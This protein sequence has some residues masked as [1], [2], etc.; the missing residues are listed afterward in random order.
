MRLKFFK[1]GALLIFFG[2]RISIAQDIHFSHE[3][4]APLILNPALAGADYET[5]FTN[6]NRTQWNSV[7]APYKTLNASFDNRLGHIIKGTSG[8]FATGINMFYDR[9]G[10]SKMSTASVMASFASHV[11]LNKHNTFGTALYFGL[12]QRSF[13]EGNLQ[14]AN[15]YDGTYFQ[16]SSPTGENFEAHQFMY[17]D[18]G[19]GVVYTFLSGGKYFTPRDKIRI[20]AGGALFHVNKPKYSFNTDSDERLFI[21]YTAFVN[22]LFQ[23]QNSL[24]TIVPGAYLNFQG[25]AKE[26]L[27]GSYIK[28]YLLKDNT[29]DASQNKTSTI[30]LG[31]FH[32][33]D[34][35]FIL[36]ALYEWEDFSAG[37]SYDLNIR[38]LSHYSGR[39]DGFE[40]FLRY[41]HNKEQDKHLPRQSICP[42]MPVTENKK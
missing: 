4:Y 2:C 23:I 25:P 3:E 21:R 10:D 1:T 31:I 16:S 33:L 8:Y 27:F 14:W 30:G 6:N 9:S 41:V 32:R 35:A 5:Q 38:Q 39:R 29:Q 40:I 22:G 18:V 15:Q 19:A 11:F 42:S 13:S 28:Y 37:V 7:Q 17:P 24:F 34:E 36:K 20:N 26:I 12:G